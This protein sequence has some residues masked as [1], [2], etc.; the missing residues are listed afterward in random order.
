M[1]AHLLHAGKSYPTFFAIVKQIL[2]MDDLMVLHQLLYFPEFPSAF[3]AFVV[4]KKAGHFLTFRLSQQLRHICPS[5]FQA[6]FGLYR[7]RPIF[8][9]QI[10]QNSSFLLKSASL[11]LKHVWQRTEPGSMF[12]CQRGLSAMSPG[13]DLQMAQTYLFSANSFVFSIWQSLHKKPSIFHSSCGLYFR[14][15]S[16][17]QREQKTCCLL[18]RILNKIASHQ[19]V[20]KVCAWI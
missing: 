17:L 14:F 6:G 10:M 11:L 7:I 3:I 1:V 5:I 8:L 12:H 2:A 18:P 16:F 13:S 4:F 20:Q 9:L 19:G 15:S